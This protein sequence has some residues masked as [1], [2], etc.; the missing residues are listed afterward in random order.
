MGVQQAAGG[1]ARALTQA[2]F[3]P[4]QGV[5]RARRE[6]V[7]AGPAGPQPPWLLRASCWAA[8]LRPW[9]QPGGCLQSSSVLGAAGLL[10]GLGSCWAASAALAGAI[11][12]AP[13]PGCRA[14]ESRLC[15][16]HP[17]RCP[18]RSPSPCLRVSG[19]QAGEC[20]LSWG[21]GGFAGCVQHWGRNQTWELR[22][23]FSLCLGHEALLSAAPWSLLP[24]NPP[25]RRCCL[26]SLAGLSL[27]PVTGMWLWWCL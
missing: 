10:Q 23:G 8:A 11:S 18:C 3:C 21:C 20:L 19:P 17:L 24:C 13:R 4:E 7:P 1:L 6:A 22:E 2:P 14:A 12:P 16:F 25:V 9:Q 26:E 27:I 15:W 5:S